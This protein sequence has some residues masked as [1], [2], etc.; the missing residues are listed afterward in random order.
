MDVV[1]AIQNTQNVDMLVFIGSLA[2]HIQSVQSL[3]MVRCPTVKKNSF[4][5]LY[6]L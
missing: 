2:E 3:G 5:I 1:Q 6:I 4:G